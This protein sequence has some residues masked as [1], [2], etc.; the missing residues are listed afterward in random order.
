MRLLEGS[1]LN[2]FPRV[3]LGSGHTHSDYY[4][5]NAT[6]EF[7]KSTPERKKKEEKKGKLRNALRLSGRLQQIRKLRLSPEA[8]IS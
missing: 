2:R 3:S 5:R 8:G 7:Q 6:P 4:V 1:F